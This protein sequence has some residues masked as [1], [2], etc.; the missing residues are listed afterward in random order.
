MSDLLDDVIEIPAVDVTTHETGPLLGTAYML[1]H[2]QRHLREWVYESTQATPIEPTLEEI[3]VAATILQQYLERW[4]LW[5]TALVGTPKEQVEGIGDL[6]RL[7]RLL[8]EQFPWLV[9]GAYDVQ[10]I[11]DVG[12]LASADLWTLL[13]AGLEKIA[14]VQAQRAIVAAPPPVA[15]MG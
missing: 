13:D 10:A 15:G 8:A 7:V 12:R 6:R 1:T 5:G 4:H 2:F 3:R 9:S 14:R 11:A